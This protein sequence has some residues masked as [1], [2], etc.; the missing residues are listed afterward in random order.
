MEHQIDDHNSK[1]NSAYRCYN[2]SIKILYTAPI[3]ILNIKTTKNVGVSDSHFIIACAERR[4]LFPIT[5]FSK[6]QHD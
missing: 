5:S 2:C 6:Y 4:R 1:K 3:T